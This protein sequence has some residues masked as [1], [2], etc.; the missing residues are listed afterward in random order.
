M[1]K[2]KIIKKI[3]AIIEKYGG[4]TIADVEA[5]CS[6]CVGSLGRMVALAEEF[7][8]NVGVCVY[9][10]KGFSSDAIDEYKMEYEELD[11]EILKEILE[12]AKTFDEIC[13]QDS[14][15]QDEH[16]YEDGKK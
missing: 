1:K 3:K 2:K 16:R 14:L 9:D 5:D 11:K 15:I 12:M 4:F 13:Y 6:P 8:C 7:G 10:P